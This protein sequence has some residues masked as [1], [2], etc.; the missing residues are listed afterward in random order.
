MKLPG[1]CL[2]P[3]P[4]CEIVFLILPSPALHNPHGA[5]FKTEN[6]SVP[7]ILFQRLQL[8]RNVS[9]YSGPCGLSPHES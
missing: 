8:M 1:C 7:L 6:I 9:Y 4:T 2:T 3:S 5:W